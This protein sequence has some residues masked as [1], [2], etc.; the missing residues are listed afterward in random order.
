[1]TGLR[2]VGGLDAALRREL[3]VNV[4]GDTADRRFLI[5]ARRVQFLPQAA[6]EVKQ[7]SDA[8]ALP[9]V[10]RGRMT[11]FALG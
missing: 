1:M 8:E 2:S 3:F 5:G 11:L 4:M 7:A 6:V 9:I 10:E